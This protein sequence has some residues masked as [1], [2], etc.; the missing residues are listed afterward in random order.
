[1]KGSENMEG[2]EKFIQNKDICDMQG[3]CPATASKIIK[4][5]KETYGIQDYELPDQTKIPLSVYQYHFRKKTPA[6]WARRKREQ[7]EKDVNPD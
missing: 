7:K 1:M 4:M 3:C 5:L 6:E 2:L